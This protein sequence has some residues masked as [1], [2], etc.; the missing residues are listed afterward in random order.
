MNGELKIVPW[1]TF[2][3]NV[4]QNMLAHVIDAR[5]EFKQFYNNISQDLADGGELVSRYGLG[6]S[7]MKAIELV[8]NE[9][10]NGFEYRSKTP[11]LV[12]CLYS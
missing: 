8:E 12:R 4:P 6:G 1:F 2:N 5:Y 11:S 10:G 9:D 3:F 7:Q